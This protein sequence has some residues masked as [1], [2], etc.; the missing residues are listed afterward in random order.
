MLAPNIQHMTAC[1][2]SLHRPDADAR[3][4]RHLASSRIGFRETRGLQRCLQIQAVIDH[5]RYELSMRQRLIRGAKRYSEKLFHDFILDTIGS[6][7]MQAAHLD[8]GKPSLSSQI[9]GFLKVKLNSGGG[10]WPVE[11]QEVCCI[12]SFEFLGG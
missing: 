5:I 3:F 6:N 8:G 7:P 9:R 11:L 4:Y 2:Q 1:S 12:L 10:G